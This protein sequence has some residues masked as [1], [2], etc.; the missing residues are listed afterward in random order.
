MKINKPMKK[1]NNKWTGLYSIIAI[2]SRACAIKLP[3]SMRIFPVFHNSLLRPTKLQ[4]ALP[5]QNLI[6]DAKSRH[7]KERILTKE[8]EKQK[9]V[10]K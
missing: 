2:Y 4:L 9:I 6:N 7:I 3:N 10:E 1:N 8:D 5:G